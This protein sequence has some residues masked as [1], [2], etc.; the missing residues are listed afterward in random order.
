V[1]YS[2]A[3]TLYLDGVI[4]G[5]GTLVKTG[6]GSLELA[7]SNVSNYITNTF[8]G[9]INVSTGSLLYATNGGLPSGQIT[10]AGGTTIGYVNTSTTSSLSAL[11]TFSL[12]GTVTFT[13]N[14]S[15]QT[16][17]I[18]GAVSGAGSIIKTGS[19]ILEF[20]GQNTYGGTTLASSGA[21]EFVN[22]ISLYNDNT[23]S[24]NT[25]NII[26]SPGATLA[27]GV[28][29]G[30]QFTASDLSI[31]TALGTANAGFENGSYIGLDTTGGNYTYSQPITNTN[32]N[33]N[34]IGLNKL[35]TNTLTLTGTNTY[36]G[37]TYVTNGV[38]DF[39]VVPALPNPNTNSVTVL[40]GAVAALGVGGPGQFTSAQVDMFRANQTFNSG[41]SIGF[42]TS[43]ASSS[44]TYASAITNSSAGALGVYVTGSNPLILTG[45]NTY[46]GTTNISSGSTLIIANGGSS[47]L[48]G[49]GNVV[50]N[51]ILEFNYGS[52]VTVTVANLI[53]GTGTVVQD[54]SG[55]VIMS[56]TNN[57]QAGNSIINAGVLEVSATTNGSGSAT[58]PI[59]INSGAYRIDV[60]LSGSVRGA[61]LGSTTSTI[62][63]AAGQLVNLT[64]LISGSNSTASL[65][66]NGTSA[67]DTGTLELTNANTYTGM[68]N[69]N[70]G[71][72]VANNNSNGTSGPFGYNSAVTLA[73]VASSGIILNPN[74]NV[75]IG[76]LAG[77]GTLGGTVNVA[78]GTLTTGGNNTVTS[79]AGAIFGTGGLT[80]V[81]TGSQTLSGIDTYTGPTAV[82]SG[83]LILAS[84]SSFPTGG[85]LNISGGTASV[86]PANTGNAIGI[87]VGQLNIRTGGTLNLNTN[88]LVVHGSNLATVWPLVRTGYAGGAWNGSGGITSANATAGYVTAATSGNGALTAIGVILNDTTGNYGNVSGTALTTTFAGAATVAGDV[89][90]KYTY[91][92][93]TNLSGSV[94]G[95]DY[96]NIDNGYSLGL[97]GWYN[98]DFNYDGAVNGSDYTLMDNAFNSQGAQLAGIIASPDAVATDQIAGATSAVPEPASLGLFGV[99]ALGLL[100]RRSRRK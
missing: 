46:G 96:A 94:D 84:T 99:A 87:S 40:S 58:T 92:G 3:Q 51:G 13:Y 75:S 33:A 88:A 44:F 26:V 5:S 60:T 41:A 7:P 56:S 34:V 4:S 21:L 14:N 62:D 17:N 63:I 35:G 43:Q 38:L 36:T 69:V 76:S 50:D 54:G 66:V 6:P 19:T 57:S 10:L 52:G 67:T 47:G 74:L 49:T 85:A 59:T 18:Q 100:G 82:T 23:S 80:I 2:S 72:L 98:G 95:S 32:G 9:G 42:D 78:G 90:V 70:A 16:Y 1:N 25:S 71:Y 53:S 30:G 64:G 31:L 79:F 97:T 22:E 81:G 37:I 89:L 28:G 45:A 20:S 24:W 91:Y 55:T 12:G 39:Q 29:G 73:N 68:T 65:N 77:G 8:T 93:D 61:T 11:V 48:L 83:T 27:F 15:G 86:A